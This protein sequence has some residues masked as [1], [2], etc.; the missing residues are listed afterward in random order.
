MEPPVQLDEINRAARRAERVEHQPRRAEVVAMLD[1]KC[2][3]QLFFKRLHATRY[4]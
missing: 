4:R 1:R 3:K 2:V